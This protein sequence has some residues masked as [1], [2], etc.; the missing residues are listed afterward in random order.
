MS[1]HEPPLAIMSHHFRRGSESMG[2]EG[3][4]EERRHV[5]R[6]GREERGE[7]R[8]GGSDGR[9]MD[10]GLEKKENNHYVAGEEG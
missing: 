10:L 5:E 2:E 3:G 9:G 8:R 4:G 6:R 1:H 7:R